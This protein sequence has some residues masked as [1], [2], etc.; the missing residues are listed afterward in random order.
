MHVV[1]S[2]SKLP[3]SLAKKKN[4]KKTGGQGDKIRQVV[5]GSGEFVKIWLLGETSG[6]THRI[7]KLCQ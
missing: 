6:T 2:C 4:K 3:K 7:M 5:H 1:V